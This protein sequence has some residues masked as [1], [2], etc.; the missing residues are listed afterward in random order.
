MSLGKSPGH[1]PVKATK[2]SKRFG[3]AMALA[4]NPEPVTVDPRA[5]GISKLNR[6]FSVKQVHNV[7]L[8]S[9]HKHGFDPRRPLAGILC[10]VRNVAKLE[11]LIAHNKQLCEAPGMPPLYPEYIRFEC[12]AATHLNVSIRLG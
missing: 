11:A 4:I 6:L 10:E 7:L 5:I 9:I 2:L 8:P 3:E 1:D 12:L